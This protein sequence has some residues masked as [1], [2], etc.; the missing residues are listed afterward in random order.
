MLA[1]VDLN[2]V[3]S[4]TM[5][6]IFVRHT[7]SFLALIFIKISLSVASSVCVLWKMNVGSGTRSTMRG[8][9]RMAIN[10][11]QVVKWWEW[12]RWQS[13]LELTLKLRLTT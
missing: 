8:T 13:S 4:S 11:W 9:D 6:A 12:Q 5:A 7:T 10:V 3:K 2:E 1:L